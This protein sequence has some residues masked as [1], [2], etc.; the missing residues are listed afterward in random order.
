MDY[1]KGKESK[2]KEK[3]ITKWIKFFNF[4]FGKPKSAH[5]AFFQNYFYGFT[6]VMIPVAVYLDS[7]QIM[8][9]ALLCFYSTLSIIV[10]REKYTTNLGKFFYFPFPATFGGF[11]AYKIGNYIQTIL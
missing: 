11:T 10:N 8:A 9:F 7:D 5:R 4:V 2:S 3:G 1:F 6:G